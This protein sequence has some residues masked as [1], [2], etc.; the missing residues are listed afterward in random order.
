M[1]KKISKGI[2]A[3]S[4]AIVLALTIWVININDT[5]SVDTSRKCKTLNGIEYKYVSNATK[6]VY[7]CCPVSDSA[8]IGS[9]GSG[10]KCFSYT[11]SDGS[12]PAGYSTY[13][14]GNCIANLGEFDDS[15]C[16]ICSGTSVT[17][18]NYLW[19]NGTPTAT[20]N[21][22]TWTKSDVITNEASCKA[23]SQSY[24]VTFNVNNGNTSGGKLYQNGVFKSRNVI[25][26]S[27]VNFSNFTAEFSDNSGKNYKFNGW[28]TTSSC[29][30]PKKTGVTKITNNTT[31]YAC[32]SIEVDVTY[33]Y[34]VYL[35]ASSVDGVNGVVYENNTNKN[36]KE[37]TV[38][39]VKGNTTFDLSKYSG[40]ISGYTFKGWSTNS[41]CSSL[42]TSYK[43][44]GNKRF[45]AC[46]D[47]NGDEPKVYKVTFDPDGGTW[48][49]GGSGKKVKEYTSKKYFT[50]SDII[51][52]KDG[53]IFKGWENEKGDVFTVYV[54]SSDDG[55]YLTAI[56]K[57]S[58]TSGGGSTGGGTSGG[59]STDVG[60]EEN[61]DFISKDSCEMEYNGYNCVKDSNNCYVRGSKKQ[62]IIEEDCTYTTKNSCEAY[63]N[64]YNCIK[65]SN[66]CYIRGSKK[67]TG[68]NT[69]GND[70]DISE[71]DP[72]NNPNTGS[73]MLYIAYLVGLGAL[74]SLGYSF[75]V[76]RKQTSK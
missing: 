43:I 51:V 33:S 39:N 38:S 34:N 14:D 71:S 57:S 7:G 25:S 36:V 8:K 63:F 16:Y 2:V 47:K 65:D 6:D 21:G 20:C 30:S 35:N 12:C 41:S 9:L 18:T 61:C 17:G 44:T 56:W 29:T 48:T 58:S 46:Y 45:Y 24:E 27:S 3:G 28:D 64:G 67:N 72:T 75:Y 68:G 22:G 4:L 54:D 76:Y 26:L 32:Y 31:Y 74:F 10:N 69:G 49:D 40:K 13:N 52:K 66:N 15:A 5:Y 59:G 73:V 1:E 23:G 62:T 53:Y 11:N 37:Y 55:S 42:I 19:N 60:D 50:D 70:S